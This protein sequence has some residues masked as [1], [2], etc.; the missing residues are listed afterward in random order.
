MRV[1]IGRVLMIGV[2]V[3]VG[4]VT[5]IGIDL[6]LL[7][8]G[9]SLFAV[10]ADD[11]SFQVAAAKSRNVFNAQLVRLGSIAF[12]ISRVARRVNLAIG[13]SITDAQSDLIRI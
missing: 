13:S 8:H 2:E 12:I 11:V 9:M 4:M 1:N 5:V 7:L 10:D 3:K 6:R